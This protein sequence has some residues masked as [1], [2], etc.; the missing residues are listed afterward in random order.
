MM[1]VFKLFIRQLGV[2]FQAISGEGGPSTDPLALHHVK[3]P[4][5][6]ERANRMANANLSNPVRVHPIC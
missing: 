2:A 1:V 4:P 5:M 3:S 6:K